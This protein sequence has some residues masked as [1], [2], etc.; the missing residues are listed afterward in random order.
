MA[1]VAASSPLLYILAL[2]PLKLRKKSIILLTFLKQ[3]D[4]SA[5]EKLPWKMHAGP[6]FLILAFGIKGQ[7]P[8]Y[9]NF[10]NR[11][12]YVSFFCYIASQLAYHNAK[13]FTWAG[14]LSVWELLATSTK[15]EETLGTIMHQ[16]SQISQASHCL[17][18]LLI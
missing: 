3:F 15:L 18:I 2:A 14:S 7:R 17:I 10:R 13:K 9:Y 16:S 4:C 11:C 1:H 8:K 12:V 5:L 6:T